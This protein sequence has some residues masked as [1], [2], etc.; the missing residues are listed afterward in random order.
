MVAGSCGVKRGAEVGG[1]CGVRVA[2]RGGG[3]GAG[4]LGAGSLR[5]RRGCRSWRGFGRARGPSL[6]ARPRLLLARP[7]LLLARPPFLRARARFLL[8]RPRFAPALCGGVR[9]GAVAGAASGLA[10]SAGSVGAGG[11]RRGQATASASTAST[12]A[13]R[14]TLPHRTRAR[15]P[16][17]RRRAAGARPRVASID[18]RMATEAPVYDL[19]LLLDAQV[20]EERRVQL[21]DNVQAAIEK[22]GEVVG[23]HDW[24]VRPT[25]YEVQ[26]RPDADYHLFQFHGDNAL[27]EQLDHTLKITDGV[28]RFRIIKLRAGTPPPPDLG[29]PA[30]AAVAAPAEPDEA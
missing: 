12:A 1:G 20:D 18:R 19:V 15:M 9:A 3:V 21:L 8:A 28:L 17:A 27:L 25:V 23:R 10:S 2:G 11:A 14:P 7:R 6:L 26:K 4:A 16:R 5:A 13:A 24:G 30:A 29:S 22:T